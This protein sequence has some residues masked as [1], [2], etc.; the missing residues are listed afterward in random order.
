MH[1]LASALLEAERFNA[2]YAALVVHSFSQRDEWFDDF[3]SFLA[4]FG[5][6]G[7]IG[8]LVRLDVPGQTPT[9]AGWAR[10]DKRFLDA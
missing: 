3:A 7:D 2:S 1:R 8:A 9:F 4:L 10:G 6:K 5:A